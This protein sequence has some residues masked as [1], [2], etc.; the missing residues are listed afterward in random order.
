MQVQYTPA[1][2]AQAAGNW[3]VSMAPLYERRTG[4]RKVALDSTLA[5]A[6]RWNPALPGVVVGPARDR[7]VRTSTPARPLPAKDED[8]KG[9]MLWIALP[10]V[11]ASMAFGL[12]QMMVTSLFVNPLLRR[13]WRAR[14]YEAD[15]TAVELTRQPDAV[16]KGLAA[17]T[18]RGGVVPGTEPVAHLFVVGPE[19][20]AVRAD[21]ADRARYHDM[22]GWQPPVD[23]R[24]GRLAPLG[25]TVQLAI[26]PKP[27]RSGCGTVLIVLVLWPLLLVLYA[28]LVALTLAALVIGL[29][30]TGIFLFGPALFLHAMLR[31]AFS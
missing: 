19:A 6:S 25:A 15:A 13:S 11:G 20:G 8:P 26:A 22:A 21:A 4:P 2:R 24:L 16:A 23:R 17:L 31:G 18:L 14:R 9:C 7:F 12:N 29:M 30:V 1:E 28:I 5:P 10:F 3:R 27:P